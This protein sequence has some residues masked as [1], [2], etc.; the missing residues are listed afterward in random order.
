MVDQNGKLFGKINLIDLIILLVLAALIVTV[1]LRVVKN[2]EETS[3]IQT[4]RITFYAEEVPDYVPQAMVKGA[5]CSDVTEN[6][7]LGTLDSFETGEPLGYVTNTKGQVEAVVRQGYN[8][9]SFTSIAEGEAIDHGVKINGVTY[10]VGHS[11]TVYAG[12]A[13]VYCRI[14][15]IEPAA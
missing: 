13:K 3:S 10:A 4:V 15:A 9:L 11:L 1:A 2:R 8:S 14:K 6:S 5:S 12:K 7:D